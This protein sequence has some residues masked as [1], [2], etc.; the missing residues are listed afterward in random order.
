MCVYA[1]LCPTLWDSLD[2]SPLGSS[3]PWIFQARILKWVVIFFSG[4]SSQPRDQTYISFISCI[5]KI[6][7]TVPPGNPT[8]HWAKHLSTHLVHHSTLPQQWMICNFLVFLLSTR[9]RQ[10]MWYRL[11]NLKFLYLAYLKI[12]SQYAIQHLLFK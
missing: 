4:G 11:F 3:S 6:L 5:G 7:Y 9:L 10:V 8:L 1:Q 2:C 12:F